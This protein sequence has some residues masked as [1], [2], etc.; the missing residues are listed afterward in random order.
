VPPQRVESPLQHEQPPDTNSRRWHAPRMPLPLF[1]HNPLAGSHATE[2]SRQPSLQ[3]QRPPSAHPQLR[4]ASV[5]A[6]V[7]PVLPA[8]QGPE[9]PSSHCAPPAS[10]G[11]VTDGRYVDASAHSEQRSGKWV[12]PATG[13]AIPPLPFKQL[14]RDETE[15]TTQPSGSFRTRGGGALRRGGASR[16]AAEVLSINAARRPS[17]HHLRDGDAAPSGLFDADPVVRE[18]VGND[19]E[20]GG[21]NAPVGLD[22]LL[23]TLSAESPQ[24]TPGGRPMLPSPH[25]GAP[26]A[27]MDAEACFRVRRGAVRVSPPQTPPPAPPHEAWGDPAASSAPRRRKPIPPSSAGP[28]P[29]AGTAPGSPSLAG[30]FKLSLAQSLGADYHTRPVTETV[31]VHGGG[32]PAYSSIA[33]PGPR[34]STAE[35]RV[36]QKDQAPR[37]SEAPDS[38]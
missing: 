29:R 6:A 26:L 17:Q 25:L 5:T 9:K 7:T 35:A 3:L 10:F 19:G 14:R 8:L 15:D 28:A 31:I 38:H 21:G 27:T 30:G 2:L 12:H 36:G 4:N 33:P 1:P 37:R 34:A 13:I 23:V 11:A 24:C 18:S 32:Q 16:D 22:S 20:T